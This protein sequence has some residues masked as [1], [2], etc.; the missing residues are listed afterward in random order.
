MNDGSLGSSLDE[1]CN[2]MHKLVLYVLVKT[3]SLNVLKDLDIFIIYIMV[4]IR[5]SYFI[6]KK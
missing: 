3:L 5:Y 4:S 1:E 2:S 6:K